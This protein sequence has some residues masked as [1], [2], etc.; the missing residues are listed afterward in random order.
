MDVTFINAIHAN[1]NN[2]IN[3]YLNVLVSN[4]LGGMD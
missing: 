3:Y 2:E 1:L 4:E